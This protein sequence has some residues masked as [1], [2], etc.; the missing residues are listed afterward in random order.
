MTKDTDQN[1][2]LSGDE[3]V[4]D[5]P[6]A[7]APAPVLP[8][9]KRALLE[10]GTAD[11]WPANTVRWLDTKLELARADVSDVAGLRCLVVG[12][13]QSDLTDL[14][15]SLARSLSLPFTTATD[16]LVLRS[17]VLNRIHELSEK[18]RYV[19]LVL[20]ARLAVEPGELTPLWN[21]VSEAPFRTLIYGPKPN[22][23][24]SEAMY[25]GLP[26]EAIDPLQLAAPLGIAV[27]ADASDADLVGPIVESGI[28][29]E[30]PLLQT[31]S[32]PIESPPK[33]TFESQLEQTQSEAVAALASDEPERKV[34]QR[35]LVI[36]GVLVLGIAAVVL[37]DVLTSESEPEPPVSQVVAEPSGSSTSTGSTGNRNV[38]ISLGGP[39]VISQRRAQTESQTAPEPAAA[40]EEVATA[41]EATQETDQNLQP[42]PAAEAIQPVQPVVAETVPAPSTANPVLERTPKQGDTPAATVSKTPAVSEQ[43]SPSAETANFTIQLVALSR[44]DYRDAYLDR[45]PG[46]S[47]FKVFEV[48]RGDL[49][50]NFITWDSFATRAAAQA[51]MQSLPQ[52]LLAGVKPEVVPLSK[53]NN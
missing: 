40:K 8:E 16:A 35:S 18:Q 53:F 3:P 24:D 1:S 30:P 4:A 13:S 10:R 5:A 42:E 51:A 36:G 46:D 38:A 23:V 6:A 11:V 9:W 19:L 12:I 26:L 15:R 17:S 14:D 50:L 34:P 47:R 27:D 32:E 48:V 2:P 43:P 7:D 22:F 29:E 28:D 52:A 39:L 20:D 37:N 44:T 45:L 33:E 25:F 21:L 49:T 41:S 31:P